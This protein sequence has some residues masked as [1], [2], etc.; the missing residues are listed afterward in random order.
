[1]EPHISSI[2]D[3]NWVAQGGLSRQGLIELRTA[4]KCMAIGPT[5]KSSH[6]FMMA[7]KRAYLQ[8]LQQ[9][10]TSSTY[11]VATQKDEDIYEAHR[12]LTEQLGRLPVAAHAYL[13]GA[14]KLHKEV[15]SMRWI[16][17]CSILLVHKNRTRQFYH[18]ATSISAFSSALGAALRF[19]MH[20]L[21]QNYC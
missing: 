9:E 16:A 5:D 19:C 3:V 21:E 12:I 15:A 1:M 7:C 11:T 2:P 4:Q 10:L 6:D 13:Y 20:R 8:G 18:A 14:G 17:G